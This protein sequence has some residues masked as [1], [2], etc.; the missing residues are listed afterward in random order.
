MHILVMIVCAISLFN[1]FCFSS[2]RPDRFKSISRETKRL[3]KPQVKIKI[4]RI[5]GKG[6]ADIK[7]NLNQSFD[8]NCIATPHSS[9]NTFI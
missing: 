3:N 5:I 7:K 6:S 8:L 2:N 1:F 9:L 4:T